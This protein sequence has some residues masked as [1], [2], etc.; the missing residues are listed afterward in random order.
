MTSFHHRH[1]YA[2][3]FP[4]L[5]FPCAPTPV[6]APQWL[7][8]NHVLADELAWP[9]DLRDSDAG[10]ALFSGNQ[11]PSWVKPHALAY[12]GHQFAQ[13]VPQLGD[14]RAILL[15][16]VAQGEDWVDVQLKGSGRTPF[17]RGGESFTGRYRTICTASQPTRVTPAIHGLCY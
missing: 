3:R 12:A 7:A 9:A 8:F 11:L 14:G 2:T 13:F 4:R 6:T 16:E 15:G 10:L 17:S 1:S 5:A